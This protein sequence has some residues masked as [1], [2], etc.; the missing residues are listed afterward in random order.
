MVRSRLAGDD[1]LQQAERFIVL[2]IQPG[3]SAP[4]MA[5]PRLAVRALAELTVRAQALGSISIMPAAVFEMG[6]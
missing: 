4:I 3:C 6:M 1:T 5:G 2:S